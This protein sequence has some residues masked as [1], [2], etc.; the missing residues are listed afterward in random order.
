MV[1]LPLRCLG[2]VQMLKKSL[3]HGIDISTVKL[4]LQS[5]HPVCVSFLHMLDNT[6]V[7]IVCFVYGCFACICVCALLACPVSEKARRTRVTEGCELWFAVGSVNQDLWKSRNILL[8]LANSP[9]PY[10]PPFS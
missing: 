10:M 9:V 3:I 5:L 7:G 1:W 6:N 8:I 2:T 4:A